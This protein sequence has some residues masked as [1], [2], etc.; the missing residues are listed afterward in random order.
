MDPSHLDLHV[1]EI[2]TSRSPRTH[3]GLVPREHLLHDPNIS[4]RQGSVIL[5]LGVIRF[6]RFLDGDSTSRRSVPRQVREVMGR[7]AQ[8]R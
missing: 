6:I 5:Q 7:V 2:R 3:L 8:S 1:P 4:V